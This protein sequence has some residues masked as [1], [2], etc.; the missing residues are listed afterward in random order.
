MSDPG[1]RLMARISTS[2]LPKVPELSEELCDRVWAAE[3]EISAAI[4]LSR[5][6]LLRTCVVHLT[7]ILGQL[8]SAEPLDLRV[9]VENGRERALQG[10]PLPAVLHGYRIGTQYIW[11]KLREEADRI[12]ERARAALLDH[13]DELWL[14]LDRY[15]EAFQESYRRTVAERAR[16]S[17]QERAALLHVLLTGTTDPGRLAEAAEGLALPRIGR[18]RVV[19]ADPEGELDRCER[20]LQAVGVHSVWRHTDDDRVGVLS[21]PKTD[22]K[23]LDDALSGGRVGVSPTY[24]RID[25]TVA[26]VRLARLTSASIE[27]GAEEVRHHGAQPVATLVAGAADIAHDLAGRVLGSLLELPEQDRALLLDTAWQWYEHGGSTTETAKALYCHRN[28]IRY[29]MQR[30]E[31]LT[32]RSFADPRH[33]A[34]LFVALQA[35][36]LR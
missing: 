18:F 2:L 8:G 22:P 30:I 28:T 35:L 16:R 10:I 13:A 36:R 14:G 1:L 4:T 12:G 25:E 11:S 32:D 20:R 15:S 33:S 5:A 17:D 3:S 29:R 21:L 31:Q 19:V 24:E 23:G 26:A 34:E 6:D 7:Q 9:P 27:P